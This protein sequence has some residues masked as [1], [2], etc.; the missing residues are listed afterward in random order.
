MTTMPLPLSGFKMDRSLES[1][2]SKCSDFLSVRVELT[3]IYV[4]TTV[5][6]GAYNEFLILSCMWRPSLNLLRRDI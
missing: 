5:G 1:S 6:E 4:D 2:V 3:Q